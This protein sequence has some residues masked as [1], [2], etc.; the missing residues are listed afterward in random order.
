MPPQEF[1]IDEYNDLLIDWYYNRDKRPRKPL[2]ENDLGFDME[3]KYTRR[4]VRIYRRN[5][6][7]E[8]REAKL[9]EI[10]SRQEA[11]TEEDAEKARMEKQYEQERIKAEARVKREKARIAEQER[12]AKEAA[13]K[14][15]KRSP[16]KG[17]SPIKLA[18]S[19]T[20]EVN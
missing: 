1:E 3:E 14:K 8:E 18:E 20:K 13:E 6:H 19:P 2:T 17:E 15:N 12:L 11:R 9:R 7:R 16:S 4:Q 10:E 5:L